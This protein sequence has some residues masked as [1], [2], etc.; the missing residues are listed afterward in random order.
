MM[1]TT[2]EFGAND[3][4]IEDMRERFQKD[5]HSV[6]DKWAAFFT[7]EQ[8]PPLNTGTSTAET[9]GDAPAPASPGGARAAGGAPARR[10]APGA[11]PGAPSPPP[12]PGH[13]PPPRRTPPPTPGPAPRRVALVPQGA[14]TPAAP[15]RLPPRTPR[16]PPRPGAQETLPATHAPHGHA[17]CPVMT[18]PRA[19]RRP[20]ASRHRCP[21]SSHP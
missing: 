8:T 19:P 5:P 21:R 4:L 7:A 2:D 12:P 14:S 11:R 17:S 13:P 10:P 20:A 3:W 1:A 6:P 18:P 9:P 15:R 16:S